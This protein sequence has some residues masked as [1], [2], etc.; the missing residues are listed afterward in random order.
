MRV[1]LAEGTGIFER[2]TKHDTSSSSF[3]D[4]DI[5]IP[6]TG[7]LLPPTVEEMRNSNNVT[8]EGFFHWFT[9]SQITET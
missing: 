2:C 1:Q 4:V 9:R 7:K 6:S 5:V 3:S 8:K